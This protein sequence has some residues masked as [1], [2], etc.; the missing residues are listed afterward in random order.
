MVEDVGVGVVMGRNRRRWPS[1]HVAHDTPDGAFSVNFD[2]QIPPAESARAAYEA[3]L[4]QSRVV[5]STS[6]ETT[7]ENIQWPVTSVSTTTTALVL[8]LVAVPN[9]SLLSRGQGRLLSIRLNTLVNTRNID[10][11][12]FVPHDISDERFAELSLDLSRLSRRF[13]PRCG[14]KCRYSLYLILS[15]VVQPGPLILLDWF[16]TGRDLSLIM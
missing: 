2:R 4:V 11:D 7:R 5:L 1:V 3:V 9:G 13:V 15:R 6:N 12:A 16:C 14:V 8:V 10:P